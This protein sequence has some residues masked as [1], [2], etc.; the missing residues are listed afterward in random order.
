MAIVNARSNVCTVITGEKLT[1]DDEEPKPELELAKPELL[2]PNPPPEKP[3]RA[4][5]ED[6]DEA[7]EAVGLCDERIAGS[8]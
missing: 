7:A 3:P 8:I 2:P 4:A 6:V 1:E 5:G